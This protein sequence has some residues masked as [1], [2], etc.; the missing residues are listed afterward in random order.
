M[1]SVKA[2]KNVSEPLMP[3]RIA[4]VGGGTAG[5]VYPAL[6]IADTYQRV[7]GNVDLQ[8]PTGYAL[9]SG[10]RTALE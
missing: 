2:A 6:A 9:R 8:L 1:Q 3:R 4:L 10:L 7:F 5:H